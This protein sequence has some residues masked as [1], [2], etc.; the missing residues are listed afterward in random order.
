MLDAKLVLAAAPAPCLAVHTV[1]SQTAA[2]SH[3]ALAAAQRDSPCRTVQVS[4]DSFSARTEAAW[5]QMSEVSPGWHS[6]A[7]LEAAPEEEEAPE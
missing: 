6:A 4:A 1:R 7:A 2:P 3:H 5:E